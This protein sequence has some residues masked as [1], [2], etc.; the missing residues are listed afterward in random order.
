MKWLITLSILV[1][2]LFIGYYTNKR[3]G[4][5][6]I[7]KPENIRRKCKVDVFNISDQ[8]PKDIIF[9]GDSQ[10]ERCQWHEVFENCAIKNRGIGGDNTE[11]LL[12]RINHILKVPPS[13]IFI[14]IGINDIISKKAPEQIVS[15]YKEIVARIKQESNKSEV[16][17]HSILPANNNIWPYSFVDNK[18]I[19]S[20]NLK[21]AEIPDCQYIDLYSKLTSQNGEILSSFTL[22]GLHLN[23]EAYLI[24]KNEIIANGYLNK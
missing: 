12:S 10:I 16:Y 21:L 17:I 8:K 19:K 23:K 5:I 13:K 4:K 1:N 24:W 14:M 7:E 6:Y 9:I 2:I 22:D 18:H 15:N 11:G 20:I 3:I